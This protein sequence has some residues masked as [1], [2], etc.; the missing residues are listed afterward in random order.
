MNGPH[1]LGGVDG[2]GPVLAE[3][4]EPVFH[5]EWE[6]RVMAMTV[7]MGF[8][9]TWNIDMM[10]H[11]RERIGNARYWSSS[12][13]EIWL[14]ALGNMLVEHKLAT[15]E[16]LASGIATGEPKALSRVLKAA[17]TRSILSA[18]SPY[19]R[20]PAAEPGFKLH[21]KVQVVNRNLK[22]HTRVPRYI[23]GKHG[24]I[25]AIRGFHVYA[26]A[27]AAGRGECPQWL[28]SVRF[29]ANE[30]WGDELT[31]RDCVLVDCWEPSLETI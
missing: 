24:L 6:R 25:C 1:D 18:G 16:E 14:A 26:V 7:A 11:A 29:T 31:G 27:N 22:G 2:F 21:D 20:E 15:R 5:A 30:L 28:Y 17:D 10:R 13:F 23:K 4:N 3:A 9:G 8:T 19:E 12:Y